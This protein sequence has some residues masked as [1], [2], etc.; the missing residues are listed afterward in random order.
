MSAVACSHFNA[1]VSVCRSGIPHAEVKKENDRI[2]AIYDER[3]SFH[4]DI[5][6]GSNR[7][8]QPVCTRKSQNITNKDKP[9]FTPYADH[10]APYTETDGMCC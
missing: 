8:G 5:T 1:A 2:A 7:F 4:V 9:P 6:D 10:T 3:C